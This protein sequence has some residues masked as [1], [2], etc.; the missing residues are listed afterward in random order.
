M[1]P[2]VFL[3]GVLL[4]LV[5]AVLTRQSLAQNHDVRLR[6]EVAVAKE[7][8]EDRVQ[9]FSRL[10]RGVSGLAH[11]SGGLNRPLFSQYVATLDLQEQYRGLL[12]LTFGFWVDD[13]DRAAFEARMTAEMAR[14]GLPFA[15]RP[16]GK[17][18][19][20]FVVAYGEPGTLNRDL[21][22]TDT[23]TRP[24]QRAAL[25]LAIDSGQMVASRPVQVIQHEGPDPGIV[26]RYPVY[27]GRQP[28]SAQERRKAL[29]GVINAVCRAQDMIQSA[30]AE[31]TLKNLSLWI[32]DSGSSI[33][34]G[35]PVRGPLPLYG[36]PFPARPT[37]GAIL[38]GH[39]ERAECLEVGGRIWTLHCRANRAFLGE[40]EW[41]LPLGILTAGLVMSALLSGLVHSVALTGQRA[42]HLAWRMTERLQQNESRLQAIAAAVPD[43]LFV[44]DEDGR[45][46]EAYGHQ[47]E[48]LTVQK[49]QLLGHTVDEVLPPEVA[50]TCM[51]GIREALATHQLQTVCYNLTTPGGR[52]TFEAHLMEMAAP[53]L[54]KRCVVALIRDITE[55]S[56]AEENL[57]R[58]QKLESLGVLA[59]GIAHDFNNLLTAILGNLNLAQLHVPADS[60]AA[61]L[62][63][64]VE[65][66][67]LRAAE[68]AHQML[69][70][71]GR[72][73]FTVALLDLNQVVGEMADLLAVSIS[74]KA[75]LNLDQAQD[76]LPILADGAQLQQV[77][78]NLVT[79]A[80][81]ALGDKDGAIT[82]RTGTETL[83]RAFLAAHCPA[84]GLEPGRYVTLVVTDTGC[85][86]DGA[87][88]GRIF[89]P[90]FTTKSTG[91]GL[92]LSAM[93]GILRGHGAGISIESRPGLGSSFRIFFPAADPQ[94]SLAVA[95]APEAA[96]PRALRG[97]I[98]V[99]DDEP[100][101]RATAMGIVKTLGLRVLGA[102]DG[103][104]ALDVYRRHR[105]EITLVFM[106]ITMPRMD[107]N[108]AFLA[109]RDL[110]PQ[111]PVILCSGFTVQEAVQ[112]PAGT[113][114]A[115]FLQK[116]Y[117]IADLKRTLQRALQ[118][119]P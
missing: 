32:E 48:L 78:M 68:L 76:L 30:L 116:P 34:G 100:V 42:R 45:Y 108:E 92:G 6:T 107:G 83:D 106:D 71:S 29:Y 20:Y 117:R 50:R 9:S 112:A 22:G 54:G 90:F 85:G 24:G 55:R 63:N 104:E 58:S 7:G 67:V 1:A 109:I 97:T 99:V 84:Q 46:L 23:L 94:E 14:E 93:L 77:V 119:A 39:H 64:R 82:L 89:D 36:T 56:R 86:M 47:E 98:L 21:L 111:L 60:Q 44:V 5:G 74:K 113:R 103:V 95:Q 57:R 53:Q 8:L 38:R 19:S 10:L 101:V 37:L 88:L 73:A 96:P 40:Q 69:A 61:P 51:D 35:E 110:D 4:S 102:A 28:G 91:R 114:P 31:G 72:G 49:G 115:D 12:A 70:Y 41:L 16:P 75:T 17:R 118:G 79:N 27:R 33:P 2:L 59:G 52:G 11:A 3:T 65:T 81:E 15:I 87:T 13:A 25:D 18:P 66:T 43:L 26:L 80:S 62:L 105:E